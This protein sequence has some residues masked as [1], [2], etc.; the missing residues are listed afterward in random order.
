MA[1]YGGN[2]PEYLKNKKLEK[3]KK[4]LLPGKGFQG[5]YDQYGREYDTKTGKLKEA[6]SRSTYHSDFA[7]KDTEDEEKH[8]Q[9]DARM[10]HGKN[11][12]EFIQD[13]ETAK[14]RLRPGE[15]KTWDKNKQQWVSNKG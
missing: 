11:W 14:N 7:K 3:I 13:V 10:K 5:R 6:L 4:S 1:V 2:D 8:R 15:V 12:K 9:K